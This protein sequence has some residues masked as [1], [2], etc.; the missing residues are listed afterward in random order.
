MDVR[1]DEGNPCIHQSTR[2]LNIFR[3]EA[4]AR[5]HSLGPGAA[6][7]I[8]QGINLEVTFRRSGGS[9]AYRDVRLPNVA[10]VSVGL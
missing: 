4:I 7:G 9:D 2:E 5:V 1:T 10:C 3:E 6:A 8:H